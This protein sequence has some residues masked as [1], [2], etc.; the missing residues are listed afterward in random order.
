MKKLLILS[1]LAFSILLS[2]NV[3]A[4]KLKE[5]EVPAIVIKKFKELHSSAYKIDYN[6]K[7]ENGKDMY[8]IRFEE[9]R[10]D[11][12]Y[13]FENDGTLYRMDG[14]I[15]TDDLPEKIKNIVEN[16][17]PGEQI[18]EVERIIRNYDEAGFQVKLIKGNKETKVEFDNENRVVEINMKFKY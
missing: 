7:E 11:F 13:F 9:E 5:S 16:K 15:P 12:E 10:Y 2:G 3:S 4:K 17:F 8:R 1:F 14:E 18:I 6:L